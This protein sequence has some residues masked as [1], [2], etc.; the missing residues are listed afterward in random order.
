MREILLE[1]ME[2]LRKT[3]VQLGLE[4]GFQDPEVLFC[5]QKLDELHN[6]LMKLESQGANHSH[7]S[8]IKE[9]RVCF[10]MGA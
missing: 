4:R 10:A 1:Q 8:M 7:H 6:Q 5:S 2:L 9:T 3:M